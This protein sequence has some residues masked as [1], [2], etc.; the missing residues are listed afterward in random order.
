MRSAAEFPELR[1]QLAYL[2][3]NYDLLLTLWGE[4]LP[5]GGDSIPR[6]CKVPCLHG[7]G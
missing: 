2:V 4:H 7:F 3:N 6:R 5:P 1:Q